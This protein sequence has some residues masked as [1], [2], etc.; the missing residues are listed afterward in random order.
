VQY[1][2]FNIIAFVFFAVNFLAS[3]TFVSMPSILLGLTSAAAATYSLNKAIVSNRP[4]I[5]SVNPSLI[6]AGTKVTIKGMN[7]FPDNTKTLS[8]TVGGQPAVG[9]PDPNTQSSRS[10]A[11]IA[12][13]TAPGGMTADQGSLSVTTS[14][15][16]QSDSYPVTIVN[17]S[18]LGW[19]SN[20]PKPGT[21]GQLRVAGLPPDGKAYGVLIDSVYVDA[22][23]TD[24][25]STTTGELIL[26]VPPTSNT[27]AQVTVTVIADGAQI[28]TGHLQLA[29]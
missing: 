16:V 1:L 3:G 12:V 5:Q 23:R 28:A 8:V 19:A 20:A 11:D 9:Q 24:D 4:I 6:A 14:A 22:R 7:L 13:F 29:T 26:T 15:T 18:L 10:S 27:A 21:Q 25:K 2:I 17:P